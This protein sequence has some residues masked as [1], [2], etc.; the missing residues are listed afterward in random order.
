[1]TPYWFLSDSDPKNLFEKADIETNKLFNWFCTNR[2][3]LNHQKTKF[4]LIKPPKAK[5][6]LT[7]LNLLIKEISLER[8]GIRFKQ[9]KPKFIRVILDT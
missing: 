1:M 4:V 2:L 3:S 9:E 6:D 5:R 8:I 7:G